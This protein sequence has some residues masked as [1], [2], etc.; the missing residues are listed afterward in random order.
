MI[1]PRMAPARFANVKGDEPSRT[2]THALKSTTPPAAIGNVVRKA[3][4]DELDAELCMATYVVRDPF[5]VDALFPTFWAVDVDHPALDALLAGE[6]GR[7]V[8]LVDVPRL[9]AAIAL[10]ADRIVEMLLPPHWRSVTEY[11]GA[12]PFEA[13]DVP[14]ALRRRARWLAAVR[15]WTCDVTVQV[16][17]NARADSQQQVAKPRFQVRNRRARR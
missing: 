17:E 6:A 15:R 1:A 13:V 14:T 16:H 2:T 3:L 10:R 7:D 9:P 8:V 5:E 12:R 4:L 11:L